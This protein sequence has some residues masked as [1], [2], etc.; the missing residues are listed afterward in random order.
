M[1]INSN[2]NFDYQQQCKKT[3]K[4]LHALDRAAQYMDVNKRIMLMKAF[5]SSILPSNIDALQQKDGTQDKQHPQESFEISL[6][7]FP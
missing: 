7:L 5:V 3:S 2:L 4:K 6:W 1:H